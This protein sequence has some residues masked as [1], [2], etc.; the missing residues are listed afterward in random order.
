MYNNIYSMT[1]LTSMVKE[2]EQQ[3][4]SPTE[5]Q[6]RPK[7]HNIRQNSSKVRFAKQVIVY[8]RLYI[9]GNCIDRIG[10][11]TGISEQD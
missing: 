9:K 2:H 6:L 5:F 7:Q 10:L 1:V 4:T 8:I 11:E 3:H